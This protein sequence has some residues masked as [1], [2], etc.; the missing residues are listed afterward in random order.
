MTIA[1]YDSLARATYLPWHET[2][3]DERFFVL[4]E[5]IDEIRTDWFVLAGSI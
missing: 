3:A 2:F 5:L 4:R 1:D